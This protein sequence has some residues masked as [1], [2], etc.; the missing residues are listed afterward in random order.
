[1]IAGFLLSRTVGLPGFDESGV[2]AHWTEG[3]PALAAECAFLWLA[4][5]AILSPAPTPTPTSTPEAS[6]HPMPAPDP[7]DLV[8]R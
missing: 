3:F 6:T 1:M 4:V 5:R 7:R 2:W 8:R